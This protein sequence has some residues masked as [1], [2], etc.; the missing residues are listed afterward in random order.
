MT[1]N[2]YSFLLFAF[3]LVC[4][5]CSKKDTSSAYWED[6]P[7]VAERVMVEGNEL[8]KLN[9]DL[10]TDT[11]VFPLS[12]FIEEPV[13]VKL[14]DRDEAL[15]SSQQQVVVSDNYILLLA[16]QNTPCKLFA[17]NSGEYISDIGG[18]G[19]GPGEYR[20][21]SS[22]H[23]DETNNRIYLFGG[24][25]SSILVYDL[26]GK[27]LEPIP[28]PRRLSNCSF[29][30]E[31]DRVQ[32]VAM[33]NDQLVDIAWTQ[34]MK[35]EMIDSIP[36]GYLSLNEGGMGLRFFFDE[37]ENNLAVYFMTLPGRAD[38]LYHID[39][40]EMKIKSRFTMD[41]GEREIHSHN[42]E[43][44]SDYFAGSTSEEIHIV[45]MSDDG[46][47]NRRTEGEKPAHYIVDKKTLKGNYFRIE[48]DYMGGQDIINQPVYL[49]KNN[50]YARNFDPG[51]LEMMLEKML[52]SEELSE[53]MRKKCIA[54][55]ENM[56]DDDNNY[57]LYAKV[58]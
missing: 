43:E 9:P 1:K 53:S 30:V 5:S 17:K 41:Y 11:I 58:K 47:T 26:T 15:V 57:I 35:G 28:L 32:I 12:F 34:T 2:N 49:F 27:V 46:T 51:N 48:N 18:I 33:P 54:L 55:Q 56:G 44:W 14:D 40:N 10:L 50:Y 20:Y 6:A 7:V 38:S 19:S 36:S 52:Q 42:Y 45:T 3:I 29:R 25:T 21:I 39:F 13:I 22:H 23:I 37:I 4:A 31:G 16:Q 24:Y 8:I